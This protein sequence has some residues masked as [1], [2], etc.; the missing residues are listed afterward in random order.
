VT[1][2]GSAGGGRPDTLTVNLDHLRWAAALMVVVQHTRGFVFKDYNADI[3][4]A[5]KL[6]YFATGFSHQ[7]VVIFFVVSGYLVG[8]KAINIIA[9]GATTEAA[10][11][12][13]IDRAARILIVL[14]PA[15]I[16]AGVV[17]AI[18]PDTSILHDAHW[19]AG[20]PDVRGTASPRQW[21][22][23]SVLLN[24][25]LVTSPSWD[26]PL[27]SL[28]FEWTYY[29]IA[30]AAL[31][32]ACRVRSRIALLFIA[33]A[34]VLV[35]LSAISRLQLLTMF[36]FWLAGAGASQVRRLRAPWLTLPLFFAMLLLARIL[37]SPWI[38]DA[39]VTAGT[40]LLIADN[41]FRAK[42]PLAW[43]GHKLAA[44]SYSLY[45][46]HFP[47]VL[48]LLAVLQ[49]RGWLATRLEPSAE[50]YG[51]LMAIVALAFVA[52]WAFARVTEANTGRLRKLLSRWLL[53]PRAPAQPRLSAESATAQL[54]NV[55]PPAA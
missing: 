39:L 12:F 36:P 37:S 50:A 15:L 9:K 24:E 42:E 30:A 2:P 44:F 16:L 52:A 3:A 11:R 54:E 51:L 26:N 21:L 10:E 33:Y 34:A 6:F 49:S 14:W 18:A 31:F 28:A 47:I 20:V 17:A 22:G 41:W 4:A 48:L 38:R 43:L 13:V 5:H 23:A 35:V 29:M 25:L 8:G 19:A 53:R 40:A 32:L 7:A 46:M 1:A 45:A 55:A 27:W